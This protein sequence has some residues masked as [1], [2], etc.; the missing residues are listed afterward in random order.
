MDGSSSCCLHQMVDLSGSG[1]KDGS[2]SNQ[3]PGGSRSPFCRRDANLARQVA[4]LACLPSNPVAGIPK[5]SRLVD[6]YARRLQLQERLT[7]Q[8]AHAFEQALNRRGVAVVAEASDGCMSADGV[9]QH[10]I[11]MVTKCW[12]GE[13]KTNRELRKAIMI[14]CAATVAETSEPSAAPARQY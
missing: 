12:R 10:G 1:S 3:R 5:L 4:H 13:F 8:I 2:L 9:K 14:R 11:S 6:T 7:T